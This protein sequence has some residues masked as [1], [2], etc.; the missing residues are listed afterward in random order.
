MKS[1]VKLILG[2]IM[3][4][5]IL[6]PTLHQRGR[7]KIIMQAVIEAAEDIGI[8]RI[9]RRRCNVLSVGVYL[10]INGHKRLL[11][12]DWGKNWDAERIC[13][14]IISSLNGTGDIRRGDN[15]ILT[16]S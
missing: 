2:I 4:F 13:E 16:I 3:E 14:H 6:S 7:E 10:V 9:T 5:L 8:T 12:N 15:L 1:P 11:Y